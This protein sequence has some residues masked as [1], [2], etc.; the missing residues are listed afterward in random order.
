MSQEA[1]PLIAVSGPW[2]F[3]VRTCETAAMT[4]DHQ[5]RGDKAYDADDFRFYL[6]L[7]QQTISRMAAASTQAKGWCIT[8]TLAALG[9]ATSTSSRPLALLGLASALLFGSLDAR[10]LREE[11]RFRALYDAARHHSTSVYDMRTSSVA[12]DSCTWPSVLKSWSLWSF[13]GPLLVVA[14]LALIWVVAM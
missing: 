10:Y 12:D 13:Y 9:L 2:P 6:G 14:A 7:I 1:N 4:D 3:T 5:S 11:R 8:V